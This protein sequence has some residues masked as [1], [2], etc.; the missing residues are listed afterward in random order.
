MTATKDIKQLISG[1][2]IDAR[3]ARLRGDWQRCWQLL[4]DAHILSQPWAWPH[5]QVHWS[6]LVAGSR[7]RDIREVRGQ[8][9]RLIVGGP[10]SA[11]GKYPLGNT[12]RARVSAV[13]PMPI[14]SDLAEVLKQ[15]GQ[16]TE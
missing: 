6:M 3:Q 2:R 11:I 1:Y 9:L 13:Q 14:R 10:A 8:I 16:R 5:I 7:L 12:G 4:E 15:A